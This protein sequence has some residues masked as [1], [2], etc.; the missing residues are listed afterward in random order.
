MP[1]RFGDMK[2]HN[3]THPD[4]IPCGFGATSRLPS[5][6]QRERV[7]RA[8]MTGYDTNDH[9]NSASLFRSATAETTSERTSWRWC[10]AKIEAH[11][12]SHL[13]SFSAKMGSYLLPLPYRPPGERS[14]SSFLRWCRPSRPISPSGHSG[15]EML[16]FEEH[17]PETF[18]TR[19]S[20]P[21]LR[22]SLGRNC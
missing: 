13:Q 10:P 4:Q 3:P 6:T 15:P 8:G 16:D 14:I 7:R 11:F 17:A 22:S 21:V 2:R 5:D 9:T 19:G 20:V 18:G 1:C 12:P